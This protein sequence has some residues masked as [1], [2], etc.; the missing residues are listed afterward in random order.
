MPF[1][2]P[3]QVCSRQG[4]AAP[5]VSYGQGISDGVCVVTEVVQA[6]PRGSKPSERQASVAHRAAITHLASLEMGDT[7]LLSADAEGIVKAWE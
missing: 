5:A 2:I 6:A 7:V 3:A 4:A 1:S